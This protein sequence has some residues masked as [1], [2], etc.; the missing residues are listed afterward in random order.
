MADVWL[1]VLENE[2]TFSQSGYI[3]LYSDQQNDKSSYSSELLPT[4]DMISLVN[5]DILNGL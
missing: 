2:Q 1:N 5:F 3:I 4:P